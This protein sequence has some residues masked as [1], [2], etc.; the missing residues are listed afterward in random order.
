MK[1]SW[2]QG[3]NDCLKT[4]WLQ[5]HKARRETTRDFEPEEFR[6]GDSFKILVYGMTAKAV[7]RWASV[8]RQDQ[9]CE[10]LLAEALK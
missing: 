6:A 10:G 7:D 5:M 9:A 3:Q 8:D 4:I 2:L 1:N